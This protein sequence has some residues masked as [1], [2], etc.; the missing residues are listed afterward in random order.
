MSPDEAIVSLFQ[1]AEKKPAMEFQ[2]FGDLL[3]LYELTLADQR[4]AGSSDGA[5]PT[6]GE[7]FASNEIA[8][9]ALSGDGLIY[10]LP[11]KAAESL[12]VV[13][14]V[15]GHRQ[16]LESAVREFLRD[17]KSHLASLG[18]QYK[19]WPGAAR[20]Y[21]SAAQTCDPVSEA[22]APASRQ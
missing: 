17:T 22:S 10:A 6:I 13:S 18:G 20:G 16:G 1:V 5:R 15:H 9:A 3:K 11:K 19:F 2:E 8:E 12:I 7:T 21:E 4:E 14:D